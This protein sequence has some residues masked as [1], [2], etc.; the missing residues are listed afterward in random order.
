MKLFAV[1]GTRPEVIKLAPVIRAA[2]QQ[3]LDIIVCATGQHREMLQQALAN[4]D[5]TP[6]VALDVMAANQT[7][8][9]LTTKL[10]HG[11]TEQI[12]A[13][14]PDWVL[15]QG[16]TTSAF[17]AG[18][19]SFYQQVKV[20]HVEAGLRTYNL[21]SPFPE[22]LNR[23][24]L[25]RIAAQH[26]APTQSAAENLMR[27]GIAAEKIVVTGNTVVDAVKLIAAR[28]QQQLP[29][30]PAPLTEWLANPKQ[31]CVFVTCHRRESFGAPL[32]DICRAIRTLC[33]KYTDHVWIFSVHPNPNVRETVFRELQAVKNLQLVDP[34]DYEAT[35]YLLSRSSLVLT[36]SGGIQEEAPSFAVPV[37][38]M[39]QHTE[40]HEGIAAGFATLAGTVPQHIIAAADAYLTV[41]QKLKDLP[42]PYGDGNA[43]ER[44]LQALAVQPV[45]A[46]YD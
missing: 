38:V 39:R 3:Q 22:E 34:L 42:N 21:A 6:D 46:C 1:V 15:V 13:H 4:F 8:P 18:L 32:I 14:Q 9:Q 45:E 10:M 35:L 44:I 7:L 41:Q 19:A 40:R 33:E 23:Q 26:F 24:L 29:H 17:I 36:D 27:E 31:K 16:D 20:G 12:A 2:K 30:F 37:V 5:L 43:S 11:L 28:W 25:S